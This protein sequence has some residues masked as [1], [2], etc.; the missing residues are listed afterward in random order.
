MASH[1]LPLISQTRLDVL[2][3]LTRRSR[4]THRPIVRFTALPF[5][6]GRPSGSILLRKILV[7]AVQVQR[8]ICVPIGQQLQIPAGASR[9][10]TSS[11]L[12]TVESYATASEQW[13][14]LELCRS[15]MEPRSISLVVSIGLQPSLFNIIEGRRNHVLDSLLTKARLLIV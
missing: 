6:Y 3:C 1:R 10:V 7:V 9:R 15:L 8:Q 4:T 13:Q 12:G 5:T 11:A 2:D 14:Y